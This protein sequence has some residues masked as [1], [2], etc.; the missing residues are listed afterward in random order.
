MKITTTLA[1]CI[2]L[3]TTLSLG[4]AKE[5]DQFSNPLDD[6]DK[7][8][9]LGSSPPAG[10]RAIREPGGKAVG[11]YGGTL[12]YR[13]RGPHPNDRAIESRYYRGY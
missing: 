8:V 13:E 6:V 11:A 9:G 4:C 7:F 1:I 2:A 5:P 10:H 3:A 12:I